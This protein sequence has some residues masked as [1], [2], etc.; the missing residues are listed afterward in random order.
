LAELNPD[1]QARDLFICGGAEVYRQA[2][3]LCSDLYLTRVKRRV[4]GDVFFPP[5]E[6]RFQLDDVILEH[7]DFR[8]LHYRNLAPLT[9]QP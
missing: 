4:E 1:A 9:V 2:L 3:P 5:F 6:E 7:A 8:I